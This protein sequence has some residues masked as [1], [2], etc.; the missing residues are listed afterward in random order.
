MMCD[1][2]GVVGVL[3]G[4]FSGKPGPGLMDF[5]EGLD[6]SYSVNQIEDLQ[7]S[8]LSRAVVH[9]SDPD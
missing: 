7:Q 1:P 2:H 8:C 3:D 6:I 9:S 5:V 4:V